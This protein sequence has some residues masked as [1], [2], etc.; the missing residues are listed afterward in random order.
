MTARSVATLAVLLARHYPK[1]DLEQVVDT[2]EEMRNAAQRARINITKGDTGE[3]RMLQRIARLNAR[4][5]NELLR[6][7]EATTLPKLT[8]VFDRSPKG[9]GVYVSSGSDCYAVY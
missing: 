2:I 3:K 1:A 5:S 8:A 6:P 4:L 7:Q 9:T